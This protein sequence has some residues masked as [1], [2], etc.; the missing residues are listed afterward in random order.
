MFLDIVNPSRLNGGLKNLQEFT[1]KIRGRFLPLD[2][3]LEVLEVDP[4]F[5]FVYS[6]VRH[7]LSLFI[8][9]LRKALVIYLEFRIG[10]DRYHRRIQMK[11]T[12]RAKKAL[13]KR[14]KIW[15]TVTELD[16]AF[17]VGDLPN[18]TLFAQR[19]GGDKVCVSL[20]HPDG[21]EWFATLSVWT[22]AD[23]KAGINPNP[24]LMNSHYMRETGAFK[25]KTL[26]V[27]TREVSERFA[28]KI[29]E[30][31]THKKNPVTQLPI[32]ENITKLRFPFQQ[33]NKKKGVRF[34]LEYY[35]NPSEGLVRIPIP[36]TTAIAIVSAKETGSM[37][38]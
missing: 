10:S 15:N 23:W 30:G 21:R 27:S 12:S 5:V 36:L 17:V 35:A 1:G 11:I 32:Y 38:C 2:Y 6:Y 3:M 29:A 26:V 19:W 9:G 25:G 33:R 34:V 24:S 31:F 13:R 8:E 14:D 7:T 37:E 18:A 4:H 22:P 16:R 28:E 20:E